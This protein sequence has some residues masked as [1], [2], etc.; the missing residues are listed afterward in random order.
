VATP[1]GHALAGYAVYRFSGP[2]PDAGRVSLLWL[3][4]IMS[5]APDLDFLPGIIMGRPALYHHGITHSLGFALLVSLTMAIFY[6]LRGWSFPAIFMLSCF[7]YSSHLVLDFF[8]YDGRPPYGIPLFWPLSNEYFISPVPFLW[9]VHHVQSTSG[10]IAEWFDGIFSLH[11]LGAIA[12]EIVFVAP[13]AWL[14]YMYRVKRS[15]Q[16]GVSAIR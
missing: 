14:A 7:A 15:K 3:C 5:V 13:F 6:A 12:L 1:I 9:G 11:N 16:A 4:V 8:G 10:S 2:A